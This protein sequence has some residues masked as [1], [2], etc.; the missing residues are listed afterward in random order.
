LDRIQIEGDRALAHKKFFGDVQLADGL[1]LADRR[2]TLF[3]L[4]K[5]DDVWKIIGFFG[6]LPLR[7]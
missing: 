6:Q 2:Q 1:T 4:N 7:G 5:R 3:R